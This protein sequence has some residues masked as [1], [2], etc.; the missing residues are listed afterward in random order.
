MGQAGFHRTVLLVLHGT[1]E[2]GTDTYDSGVNS[3]GAGRGGLWPPN[4]WPTTLFSGF[5]HTTD[6]KV[7][8]EVV[9]MSSFMSVIYCKTGNVNEQVMLTNLRSGMGSLIFLPCQQLYPFN[10]YIPS[11]IISHKPL[12]SYKQQGHSSI[13]RSTISPQRDE[14]MNRLEFWTILLISLI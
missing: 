6:R 12:P 5:S 1:S 13:P 7:Q 10:N 4:F 8:S 3:W 2:I 9:L 14:L 11:T